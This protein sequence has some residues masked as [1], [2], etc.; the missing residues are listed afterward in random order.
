MKKNIKVLLVDDEADFRKLMTFWLKSQ[1][2][3]VLE[4]ANGKKAIQLVKDENLN[5]VFLDFR[6]PGMDGVETLKE[7]R[8]I[9]KNIPIIMI[10][11][12]LDDPKL[13]RI[14][15]DEVS[16]VFYKDEDFAKMLPLLETALRIHK[17]LR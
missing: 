15:L 13:G 7:I 9:N 17:K 4:A 11:A 10:S 5:V 16:G 14:P 1:G 3:S 12:Y 2:Y 8:K 6:M